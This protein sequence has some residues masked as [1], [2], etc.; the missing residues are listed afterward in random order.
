MALVRNADTLAMRSNRGLIEAPLVADFHRR[1]A[2]CLLC[3]VQ[4]HGP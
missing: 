3:L 1:C 4:S 2:L